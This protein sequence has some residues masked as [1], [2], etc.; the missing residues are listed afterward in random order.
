M[1]K[2]YE[3]G[4]IEL[5]VPSKE[6]TSSMRVY[7]AKYDVLKT[8]NTQT[9]YVITTRTVEGKL[10]TRFDSMV[11][12]EGHKILRD[13]VEIDCEKRINWHSQIFDYLYP[14]L[15]E[16]TIDRN[17]KLE[18]FSEFAIKTYGHVEP[19]EERYRLVRELT[20]HPEWSHIDLDFRISGGYVGYDHTKQI[21]GLHGKSG[22]FGKPSEEVLYGLAPKVLESYGQLVPVKML[23]IEGNSIFSESSLNLILTENPLNLDKGY[24]SLRA[25]DFISE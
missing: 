17:K 2:I 12:N 24:V 21:L 13:G 15:K 23:N 5:A 8:N 6:D 1:E 3:I 7:G 25:K 19:K 14:E 22:D 18:E 20:S 9:K 4:H 10:L 16:F 11:L